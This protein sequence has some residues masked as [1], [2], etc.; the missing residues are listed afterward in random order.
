MGGDPNYLQVLGPDPPSTM[1]PMEGE[2]EASFRSFGGPPK[3]NPSL[4]EKR[5]RCNGG[6]PEN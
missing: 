2:G 5:E 1:V 3:K 6:K 4:Y